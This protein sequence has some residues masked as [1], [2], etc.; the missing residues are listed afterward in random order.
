MFSMMADAMRLDIDDALAKWLLVTLCDYANEQGECWPSTFTLARRTG[1]GRSTVAKKLNTL[2][3]AGYIT[4][5]PTAFTST[6]YRVSL[7]DTSVSDVDTTVSEVGSNLSVTNQETK[8]K[9]KT[10]IPNDWV[11]SKELRASIDAMPNIME[12]DHDIEEVCFREYWQERGQKR[13]SWDRQYKT[14][15]LT[16]RR[17]K[18]TLRSINGGGRA[19]A[20][21]GRSGSSD[22][23]SARY[24]EFAAIPII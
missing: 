1:M 23:Q 17:Q 11:A 18:A 10:L 15:I 2:V 4:R 24:R 19:S 7:V 8:K 21:S 9:T 16:Y 5:M 6:T 14:F 12:L 13:V 3:D 22:N 20:G